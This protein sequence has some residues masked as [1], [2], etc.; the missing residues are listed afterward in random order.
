MMSSKLCKECPFRTASAPGWI[1]GYEDP[2]EIADIVLGDGRFPCHLEVNRLVEEGKRF[3]KA[4]SEAP[5]CSG[6]AAMLSNMLK[7]SRN[8]AV[9]AKQREVGK[10]ADVFPNPTA[11][12]EHHRQ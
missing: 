7:L 11:F 6:S 8:P 1:G 5:V 3:T 12:C 4:A 10:R 2:Q 9:A